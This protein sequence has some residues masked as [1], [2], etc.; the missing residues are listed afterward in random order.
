LCLIE[1]KQYART[2]T[3]THTHTHAIINATKE[4]KAKL[5]KDDD[6]EYMPFFFVVRERD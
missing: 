4:N 1:I 2:H 6:D 3:H 5:S